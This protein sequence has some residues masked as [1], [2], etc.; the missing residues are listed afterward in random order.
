MKIHPQGERKEERGAQCILNVPQ[1]LK[2]IAAYPGAGPGEPDSALT[3]SS[4]K[5]ES[6]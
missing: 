2:P 6:L 5:E 3:I 1:Q 4:V